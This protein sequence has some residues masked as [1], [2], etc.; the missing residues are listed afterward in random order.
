M[1]REIKKSLLNNK[2]I[3]IQYFSN[4]DYIVETNNKINKKRF[5]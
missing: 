3:M 2:K 5:F 1:I 4:L